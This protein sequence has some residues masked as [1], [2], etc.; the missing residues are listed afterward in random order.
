MEA[1]NLKQVKFVTLVDETTVC[2]ADGTTR[3]SSTSHFEEDGF[4]HTKPKVVISFGNLGFE[5]TKY[6]SSDTEAKDYFDEIVCAMKLEKNVL[7]M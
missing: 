1:L 6:F 2:K 4:W 5:K 7:V 3:F